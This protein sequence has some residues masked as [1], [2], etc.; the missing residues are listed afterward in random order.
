MRSLQ[1]RRIA[2]A[3]THRHTGARRRLRLSRCRT[4]C[5]FCCGRCSKS[6]KLSSATVGS[7]TKESALTAQSWQTPI[8]GCRAGTQSERRA[9]AECNQ[10]GTRVRMF[11]MQCSGLG[12]PAPPQSPVHARRREISGHAQ[13]TTL[14]VCPSVCL[15]VCLAGWLAVWLSG[16][17]TVWLSGCLA[18][19][20]S[21][22]LSVCLSAHAPAPGIRCLVRA[23]CCGRSRTCLSRRST[24]TQPR[25]S[26]SS[27]ETAAASAALPPRP[28]QPLP[29]HRMAPA[30]TCHRGS[31]KRS[32][33]HRVPI[34]LTL[35][36][37]P[38]TNP[39]PR[40]PSDSNG[41]TGKRDAT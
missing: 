10:G 36:V 18:A 34:L 13:A 24:T 40:T 9:S 11:P 1:V 17:L 35:G 15:S 38:Q 31:F 5:L 3:Q 6:A 7:T 27:H 19:C 29:P 26:T 25:R 33:F 22:C 32:S 30:Q 37:K 20:L 39:T 16:C 41:S 28:R 12:D 4:Q 14:S 2:F 8:R 21:V 23:G